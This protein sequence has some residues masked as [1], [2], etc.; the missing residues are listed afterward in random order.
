MALTS[1]FYV[2]QIWYHIFSDIISFSHWIEVCNFYKESLL[3]KSL[4]VFWCQF[5]QYLWQSVSGRRKISLCVL[6]TRLTRFKTT[7]CYHLPTSLCWSK[8]SYNFFWLGLCLCRIRPQLARERIEMCR[9]CT[10]VTP[11]EPQVVIGQDK[12]FTFDYVF[13]TGT[14][15]QQVYATCASKLIDGFVLR[16]CLNRIS[17]FLDLFVFTF[18]INVPVRTQIL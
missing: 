15:Q 5:S 14:G 9:I 1:G 12:A 13:D 11:G 4:L 17:L 18:F 16:T 6:H 3:L 7:F 2:M 8:L 10:S